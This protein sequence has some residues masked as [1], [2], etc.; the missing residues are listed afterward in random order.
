MIIIDDR[1]PQTVAQQESAEELLRTRVLITI[2]DAARMLSVCKET[3]Q[4]WSKAGLLTGS[5]KSGKNTH[6]TAA[7]IRAYLADDATTDE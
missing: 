7:S 6:I 4:R 3:I 2:T 1:A 5:N